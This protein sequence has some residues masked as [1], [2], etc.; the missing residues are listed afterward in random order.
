MQVIKAEL[1][2]I[3]RLHEM[4]GAACTTPILDNNGGHKDSPN[5]PDTLL[6]FSKRN[7]YTNTIYLALFAS[8]ATLK[9]NIS[10]EN[11]DRSS[12]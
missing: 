8:F 12:G 3:G 7:S 11:H 6:C 10:L 2:Q 1:N 5:E 9:K 4:A